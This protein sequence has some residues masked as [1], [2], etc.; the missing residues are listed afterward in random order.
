V[1][2]AFEIKNEI[3]DSLEVWV[4]PSCHSYPVPRGSTLNLLYTATGECPLSTEMTAERLVVW[5]NSDFE[6]MAELDGRSV[7]PNVG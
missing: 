1:R 2:A 5:T 6:P 7:R 3:W 4:E